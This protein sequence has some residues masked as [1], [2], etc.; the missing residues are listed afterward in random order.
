MPDP[1]IKQ[2]TL[3]SAYLQSV[4]DIGKLFG[5]I[6]SETYGGSDPGWPHPLPL[7]FAMITSVDQITVT[8]GGT[9]HGEWGGWTNT[10]EITWPIVYQYETNH[11]GV[12]ISGGWIL[13][14]SGGNAAAVI[15]FTVDGTT[16]SVSWKRMNACK[17]N[18][19]NPVLSINNDGNF[20]ST[21]AD[22]ARVINDPVLTSTQSHFPELW[23]Q[24]SNY[25]G[26]SNLV[27]TTTVG[28]A[29][30]L[31]ANVSITDLVAENVTIPELI[32]AGATN[33][34]L[35][36][37]FTQNQI[38]IAL[39]QAEIA[40]TQ[41]KIHSGFTINEGEQNE[42][43]FVED[44]VY[45]PTTFA[46]K[47]TTDLGYDDNPITVGIDST[48][49]DS[50]PYY[51]IY[52]QFANAATLTG[53]PKDIFNIP[54]SDFS[55]GAGGQV[56]LRNVSL[57]HDMTIDAS[58]T[59]L[60]SQIGS[61]IFGENANDWCGSS[62]SLNADGTIVAVLEP[63]Y[64]NS[65]TGSF[66]GR[67]RIFQFKIP[68]TTEWDTANVVIKGDD[69]TQGAG[70]YWTQ[71]GGHINT[72]GVH[73]TNG[74]GNVALSSD[75]TTVAILH[76]RGSTGSWVSVFERNISNTTIE[77]IGWTQIGGEIVE[78]LNTSC[79]LNQDGTVLTLGASS[80]DIGVKNTGRVRVFERNDAKTE[81]VTDS[82]QLNYG[83]V[84]WSGVGQRI[85]G[86][87]IWAHFG[88][89]CALSSNGRIV[90]GGAAALDGDYI[91]G[92]VMLF[93]RDDTKEAEVTDE[94]QS[95]YGPVGWNRVGERINGTGRSNS[96]NFGQ[97]VGLSADGTIV[98]GGAAYLFSDQGDTHTGYVQVYKYKIPT[99]TEWSS[100][101]IAKGT[102]TTQTDMNKY[103]WTQLGQDID[104][105]TVGDRFGAQV[106]L[107]ADGYRVA[108]GS[109]KD[110]TTNLSYVRVYQYMDA[111]NNWEIIQH[112]DGEEEAARYYSYMSLSADG[113]TLSYGEKYYDADN[114]ATDNCGRVRIYELP[115]TI[116]NTSTI[117]AGNNF[118]NNFVN[119]IETDLV[120]YTL[121][122][123]ASNA[124]IEFVGLGQDISMNITS[125]DTTIFDT[126]ITE[127]TTASNTLPFIT[128][129]QP[130]PTLTNY[131]DN[132]IT[133]SEFLSNGYTIPQLLI[134]G[135]IPD[136]TFDTDANHLAQSYVKD[137][138]DISGSLVLRENSSLTV[139]GNIETKGN[140][141]IK[142]PTMAADLSLNY[143]MIVGG[144]ISMNGN[145]TVG[146]VSMNGK[147]VDCSFTDSS[148]PESA[149]IGTYGPD[150]TQPTI[151]YENGF[152]TTADVSMNANVQI[153]NLKVDGNI[154]FSDG[155]TMNTFDDNKYYLA[156]ASSATSFTNPIQSATGDNS[157][158]TDRVYTV[159][160]DGKYVM[161]EYGNKGDDPSKNN[162]YLDNASGDSGIALS[163]DYGINFTRVEFKHPDTG[164][165]LVN[166]NFS[167]AGSAMSY[168]GQHIITGISGSTL[169]TFTDAMIGLSADY[170][171]T[172]TTKKILDLNGISGVFTNGY[173][174]NVGIKHDGTIMAITIIGS[175]GSKTYK[176]IDY[177]ETW[178]FLTDK[179]TIPYVLY[180]MNDH[181]IGRGNSGKS[182]YIIDSSNTTLHTRS[183][184]LNNNVIGSVQISGSLKG[185]VILIGDG[186]PTTSRYIKI[187]YDPTTSNYSEDI[188][189]R[190]FRT[191]STISPSGQYMAIGQK[192]YTYSP[193]NGFD[194]SPIDFSNDYGETFTTITNL[195]SSMTG[196]YNTYTISN[197]IT[198]NGTWY[199]STYDSVLYRIN[200]QVRFKPSTFTSLTISNTLT[201]GSISTSSDYRIKTDVSQLDETITLDNLRP[202]KY[203]QTLINKPQYG[204]IAHELQEYYPDLVVGEKDGDEWQ[205]VN[206]TGLVALLI[207][208][209]KQLK[210]ELTEL[211]NGM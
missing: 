193:R 197:T 106:R 1:I 17:I 113:S 127:I 85:I 44:A 204:L 43:A 110:L 125:N 96:D 138:I 75:G 134:G 177:G 101:N 198:D 210:R 98:A 111:T 67:V 20:G 70:K 40:L 88:Q 47:L 201:A 151:V 9:K 200:L 144:D 42:S 207:N 147:V 105:K 32:S 45:N 117:P 164:V 76:I 24:T 139:N 51:R 66:N 202:V 158:Y 7:P 122:Y 181:F 141:T 135:F 199:S 26:V 13:A 132:G 14:T 77:P 184:T 74:D 131:I 18:V 83:P 173:V 5:I 206:Y 195:S 186:E 15:Q 46:A 192:M 160:S 178:T 137:F 69:T 191:N 172:W 136:W 8:D 112:I 109:E 104:G 4:A 62:T 116:A 16:P 182:V 153:N 86:P 65:N 209:I 168:T 130:D 50:T 72:A 108:I 162:Y 73:S 188:V 93:E 208:E 175:A 119:T 11:L 94:S 21:A 81:A 196:Y 103:Y 97:S 3:S 80:A 39:T 170:G 149:F 211:E 33:T 100:V 53:M 52:L 123:D 167:G 36:E 190:S 171:T 41:I 154:E 165:T 30:L 56:N 166:Y 2:H 87:A 54:F 163:T 174:A 37:E 114:G 71:L 203:L 143:N 140:I 157:A 129:G 121:S 64:D 60:F 23:K 118:I 102:D 27:F 183:V 189:P 180:I 115:A 6:P 159:S 99:A 10:P 107:S 194:L 78:T 124:L 49:T 48:T 148:I 12:D 152:D 185:N 25:Y 68:T 161:I 84:G 59:S 179:F 205:R 155:T 19:A 92:F 90:A 156:P 55:V 31:A 82:T 176:S 89:D 120:N 63:Q 146:D 57:E 35:R 126:S 22:L 187:T 61:D 142:N 79:S 95:N 133:V 34:Q 145:V 58:Y 169:D 128:Y 28:V 150:Y 91:N 29:D 38:D